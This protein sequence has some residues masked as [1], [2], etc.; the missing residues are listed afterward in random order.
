MDGITQKFNVYDFFN[1][2]IAGFASLVAFGCCNY[3]Q[4]ANILIKITEFASDSSILIIGCIAI[5][6]VVSLIVGAVIQVVEHGIIR[7]G[8]AWEKNKIDDCLNQGG[9]FHNEVRTQRIREKACIY[10]KKLMWTSE[11]TASESVAFFTHC[12]YYLHIKGCDQKTE[13]LRETQSLSSLLACGFMMTIISS[14]IIYMLTLDLETYY[15]AVDLHRIFVSYFVCIVLCIA[16]WIRYIISGTNRI[17]M[18]LSIYDVLTDELE[19]SK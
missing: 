16:F 2:V 5:V 7:Y 9:I 1:L 8:I 4:I 12:V 14:I 13:R 18:V 6:L 19:E 15:E 10:L 11:L 17:R 3:V